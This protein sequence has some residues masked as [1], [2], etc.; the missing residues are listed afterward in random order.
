LTLG[1]APLAALLGVTAVLGA[2]WLLALRDLAPIVR[3]RRSLD[4]ELAEPA[5][6]AS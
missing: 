5:R 4:R 2:R 3:Q 6:S 1:E